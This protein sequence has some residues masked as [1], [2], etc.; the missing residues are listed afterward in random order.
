MNQVYLV[1]TAGPMMSKAF[2]FDEHDTFL[3]AQFEKAIVGCRTSVMCRGGLHKSYTSC[4][5][6]AWG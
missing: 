6:R 1:I 5:M 3:F 2:S 4:S